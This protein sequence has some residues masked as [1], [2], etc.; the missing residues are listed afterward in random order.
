MTRMLGHSKAV[1]IVGSS[2]AIGLD[3]SPLRDLKMSRS[4]KH[5]KRFACGHRGFGRYCHCCADAAA[6][7]QQQA[8]LRRERKEER[9]REWTIEGV[10]LAKLPKVV[11]QKAQQILAGLRQGKH[12]G[13]LGGKQFNFD[14]DL[15]RIPVGYRYRLLCRRVE[16]GFQLLEVLSHEAYNPVMRN[17]FR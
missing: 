9:R 17:S 5:R 12:P 14:R 2:E 4:R 6:K 7:R 10:N 11:M 16:G 15:L 1:A 3:V 13:A 8:E